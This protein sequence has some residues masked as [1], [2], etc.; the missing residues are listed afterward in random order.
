MY[1]PGEDTW[2]LVEAAKDYVRGKD[3]L[4][5]CTGTGTVAI[6]M[7]K[8][9]AKRVLGVDIN[10]KAIEIAKKNSK[11]EDLNIEFRV[12]YLFEPVDGLW[13]VI[14]AKPPY[15]PE[16]SLDRTMDF[17]ERLEVVGGRR[18]DEIVL[19]ILKEGKN[20]LRAPGKIAI[21]FSTLSRM[22]R[23]MKIIDR[24]YRVIDVRVKDL[25][26]ERILAVVLEYEG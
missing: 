21:V 25:F 17:W 10:P 14:T 4:D 7:K 19:R 16:D 11:E 8:K 24:Y 6:E 5:L 15:L 9:G 3:V 20:Y 13:D 1:P 18:G 23:I 26:F 2:L 22:N 12:G